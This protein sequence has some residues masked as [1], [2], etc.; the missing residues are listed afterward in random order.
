[1]CSGPGALHSIQSWRYGVRVPGPPQEL[2]GEEKAEE[3]EEGVAPLL[4][5]RD[6]HLDHLA[7]GE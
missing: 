4:K 6:H 1:M 2:A 7:A 3:D 5:S